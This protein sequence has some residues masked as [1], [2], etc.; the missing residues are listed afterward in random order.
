MRKGDAEQ[1]RR[2]FEA[3]VKDCFGI[4]GEEF[5]RRFDDGEYN[6]MEDDGDFA[7]IVMMMPAERPYKTCQEA[8]QNQR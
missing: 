6:E 8:Q 4:T 2:Y 7:E 1:L 3:R 5:I